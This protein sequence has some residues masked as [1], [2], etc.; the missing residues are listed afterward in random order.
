[1]PLQQPLPTSFT[2]S[3]IAWRSTNGFIHQSI[4]NSTNPT[5][6]VSCENTCCRIWPGS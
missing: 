2:L 3:T 4:I 6:S 5:L 1:M